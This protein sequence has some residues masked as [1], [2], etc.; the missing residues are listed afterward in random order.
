[1]TYLNDLPAELRQALEHLMQTRW[2][3]L[4][5]ET[6]QTCQVRRGSSITFNDRIRQTINHFNRFNFTPTEY[7]ILSTLRKAQIHKAYR[8]CHPPVTYQ[9][10]LQEWE[11]LITAKEEA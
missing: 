3:V 4:N 1:M 2:V 7:F 5:S 10:L 9:T 11:K 6:F 8:L